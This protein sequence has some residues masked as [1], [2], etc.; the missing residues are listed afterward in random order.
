MHAQ[1]LDQ[2]LA[3]AMQRR[4][5]C[6]PNP[7]VGAVV[8]RDGKIIAHGHHVAAGCDHA[9]VMALKAAGDAANG[10]T[11]YVSLEPCCHQGKTPPCTSAIIRSGIRQVYY[12]FRDP[13]DVVAG[14]G[15]E[16]LQ[17]AGIGCARIEHSAT[18]AFYQSYQHWLL[19]GRPFVTA[20]LA[21]SADHKIALAGGQP[22][23]IT[24]QAAQQK[25]HWARYHSDAILTTARTVLAD[26][27]RLDA[28]IDGKS[29]AKDIFIIDSHLS[30]SPD[31]QVFN[32][33][34]TVTLLH[35]PGVEAALPETI[36][37][38]EIASTE[39][40]I[41]LAEA[42]NFIG[43][44]GIHDL[45]VEAGGRLFSE[46][47]KQDLIDKAILYRSPNRL[48]DAA[49]PAFTDWQPEHAWP[50]MQWQALGT[51]SYCEYLIRK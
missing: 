18:N 51:D 45:W 48:G 31:L 20:K 32:L 33:A 36:K 50:D 10:A 23:T 6:A 22:T 8:V 46:L 9:E 37:T 30:L 4:G 24:G 44:Q 35:K 47:A 29:I 15:E 1:Y 49:Y 41:D 39:Q 17:K 11:L 16:T 21:L 14:M 27:P 34:K 7:A 40:G 43:A 19:T 5:F 13:H 2:A 25:T 26:N 38:Q 28:R 3:L 12:A 42:M